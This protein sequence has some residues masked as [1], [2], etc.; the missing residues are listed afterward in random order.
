MALITQRC[1]AEEKVE[2][3]GEEGRKLRLPLLA[4]IVENVCARACGVMRG[5]GLG[6]TGRVLHSSLPFVSFY[7]TDPF[8]FV[9]DPH[10]VSAASFAE[11]I[12]LKCV[13]DVLSDTATIRTC[14]VKRF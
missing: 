6:L 8:F 2:E 12:K 10:I 7:L 13:I 14:R 5:S 3:R 9:L 4:V 1:V 11:N